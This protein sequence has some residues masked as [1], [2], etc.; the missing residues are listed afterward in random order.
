MSQG[1]LLW[2]SLVALLVLCLAPMVANA[3]LPADEPD[4]QGTD[5][6]VTIAARE[7][8]TYD[9]IRANLA[10]NNIMESLEDLGQDTLYESGEP[11]NPRKEFAGQPRCRPITGW[12][13]TLGS[14]IKERA[15]TGPWGSLSI[16]T[17]ADPT[18][19]VT[20]ASIPIRSWD[21]RVVS[22]LSI[23]GATT[24]ELTSAQADRSVGNNLWVQGGTTDDPVL[25]GVPEFAGKYGFGALRC[26]IDDLNGD[27]VETIAY[28][29]G[30]RHAFC[31]AYYV[32]PPPSS[33]KIVIRKEVRGS[34]NAAQSFRF[35]GNVSY[36]EDQSFNLT[37]SNGSPGS[38]E[39]YRAETGEGDDPWV[40]REVV[41]EGWALVGLTCESETS[42]VSTS[43]RDKSVS[44][45]L[46]AGDTVT[47]TY[48]DAL[49]PPVGALL[50]SKLTKGGTGTFRYRVLDSDGEQVRSA[51]ITTRRE[52]VAAYARPMLLKPGSYRVL[53]MR[54]DDPRG[55]WRLVAVSCNGHKRGKAAPVVT[56][57][58]MKGVLCAFTNR[59]VHPGKITVW[60]ETLGKTGTA[61]FR[62]TSPGQ[63]EVAIDQTAAT[64]QAGVPLRARG[65]SSRRLS[66][67]PYVIQES[68]AKVTDDGSWSL[69]R[70]ICNGRSVPFA[71]GRATVWLTKSSPSA[72][73]RFVNRFIAAPSPDPPRPGPEPPAPDPGPKPPDP[74][75]QPDLV[76]KKKLV[77]STDDAVP[78]QTFRITVTNRSRVTATDVVVTDQPGPGLVIVS[79][80]PSSG[81]CFRTPVY[82]CML[83]SLPPGGS[84]YVIVKVKNYSDSAT[85]NLATAG[86]SS[87]EVRL[88]NNRKRAAVA[89][90]SRRPEP[91]L[92]GGPIANISC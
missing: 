4:G 21:G 62:I 31:Y 64:R 2:S 6:F 91:C 36:T 52:G 69:V 29:A 51:R 65:E 66:F 27:N 89:G 61:S 82:G 63:P 56:I 80:V 58:D 10:R 7:C 86:S 81:E 71:Q 15:S 79:A 3:Q 59:L 37:A 26:S 35:E 84:A 1:R 50:I 78:V 17:G 40:V 38:V 18:P 47:C 42:T 34:G 19:V 8:P 67:G 70:V 41:P 75:A 85:Y 32:T 46:A 74:S 73:C 92:Y 13:F 83:G 22:G 20:E 25:F 88:K 72:R 39:F 54:E 16:V 68:G 33:G 11:V 57:A 44:I 5:V 23:R 30:T 24:I 60:K 55:V 45:R 53:E 77:R 48:T 90:V 49:R 43:L 14:G 9:A 87:A 76:V 12:R 28:P